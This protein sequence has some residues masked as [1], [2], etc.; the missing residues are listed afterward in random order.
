MNMHV[1]S[2]PHTQVSKE[3][4]RCAYSQKILKFCQ[5]MVSKGNRVY[6]YASEDNE[7][8]A[9]LITCITKKELGKLGFNGAD[10]Y[11]NNDFDNSKPL[12]KIFHQRAI[13][14]MGKRI[15]KGD[16]I[17]TFSGRCDKPIAD[18]FPT[19]YFIEGGIGYS[20][21][22][23]NFRVYESYAWMHTLY[24]AGTG[25]NASI[26]DG[27]FY[28]TVI[29]N[30][31]D[32]KDFPFTE[33]KEDYILFVG[34]MI[35]RKGLKIIE[36]MAKRLTNTQFIFAGQGAVQDGNKIVCQE[37]TMQG[38]NLKYIGTI[39]AEKRASLMGK[40]KV[41]VVPTL[42]IAPFEGVSVEANMCGT[43]IITSDFG[44]FTENNIN[45]LTGYRCSTIKEF[46]Q[47]CTDVSNLDT[48]K[49]REY[50][51]SRF[52]MD[53]VSEMYIKYFDRIKGLER[54]GFYE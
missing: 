35:H 28:D 36:E 3:Y 45:G 2:Q 15:Q 43:P 33:K 37:L 48:K 12:W 22:F 50:A 44:S 46:V 39:D 14:E 8:P 20:G 51:M 32:P 47:G 10:D 30:Y 25:G 49:I 41:L 42:Y 23:A 5:M 21:V 9:E 53:I 40:A 19:A 24:G 31:F 18:A 27:R 6:L 34:R 54:G 38:D 13:Y 29:P 11:L 16:I 26:A 1:I 52:S 4:L 17:I 7:T